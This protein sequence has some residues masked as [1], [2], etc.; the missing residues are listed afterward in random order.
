MVRSL[1]DVIAFNERESTRELRW[2]GQELFVAAQ[3]TDGR[4]SAA[5]REA[6]DRAK[7]LAH[8]FE[9][10]TRARRPPRYLATVRAE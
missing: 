6:R 10:A 4:D 9:R 2:F 8:A 1:A 5:Y 3:A 7:R